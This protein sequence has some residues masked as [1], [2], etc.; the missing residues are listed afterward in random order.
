MTVARKQIQQQADHE[1]E[2]SFPKFGPRLAGCRLSEKL[3]RQ[4]LHARTRETRVLIDVRWANCPRIGTSRYPQGTRASP[5]R[6]SLVGPCQRG[7]RRA[8]HVMAARLTDDASLFP[9][10]ATLQVELLLD[11][12]VMQSRLWWR[13]AGGPAQA[14]ERAL[15]PTCARYSSGWRPWRRLPTRR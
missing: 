14:G 13:P 4:P 15:G 10:T 2:S 7:G 6:G 3:C 11:L 12:E 5:A 9:L 1:R 8:D